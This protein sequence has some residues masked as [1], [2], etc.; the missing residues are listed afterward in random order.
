MPRS[1]S[2]RRRRQ[3]VFKTLRGSGI[4]T[5]MAYQLSM[6][7]G[8]QSCSST[9]LKSSLSGEGSLQPKVAVGDYTAIVVYL[10]LRSTAAAAAAAA[11]GPGRGN[12]V[13]QVEQ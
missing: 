11:A 8:S 10:V 13:R 4:G 9:G 12:Y 6:L 5:D 3:R 7:T 2:S 1:G